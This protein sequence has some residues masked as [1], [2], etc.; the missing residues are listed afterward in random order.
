MSGEVTLEWSNTS[1]SKETVPSPV[2]AEEEAGE[3]RKRAVALSVSEEV[4]GKVEV[5]VVWVVVV[6][7]IT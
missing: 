1:V 6:V 7:P 2:L 3:I 4:R 5:E